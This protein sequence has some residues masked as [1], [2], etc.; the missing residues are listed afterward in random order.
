MLEHIAD[1][2]RHNDE[3]AH[4]ENGGSDDRPL[5]IEDPDQSSG[6]ATLTDQLQCRHQPQDAEET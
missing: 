4:D 2:C 3:D 6:R 5:L 1:A